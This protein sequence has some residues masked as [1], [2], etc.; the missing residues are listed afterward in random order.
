[1]LFKYG[2]CTRLFK[3]ENKMMKICWF[4]NKVWKIS[5]YFKDVFNTKIIP[6]ALV[7]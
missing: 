3:I 7:G 1:M 2:N 6:L 5:Q 4:T